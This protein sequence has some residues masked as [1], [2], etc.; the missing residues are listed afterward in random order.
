MTSSEDGSFPLWPALLLAGTFYAGMLARMVFSPLLIDMERELG[1]SHAAAGLFFLLMSAGYTVTMLG[2]GFVSRRL[3]HRGTVLLSVLWSAGASVLVGLSGSTAMLRAA[4]FLLGAGT[5]LYLPSALASIYDLAGK[6]HRGRAIGIHELGPNLGLFTAPL[7]VELLRRIMEWRHV[8]LVLGALLGLMA[9]IYA[10][11]GRGGRFPGEPPAFASI[12][13]FFQKRAFWILTFAFCAVAA[14]GIGGYAVLPTYLV[15]ERGLDRGL[16][17][18]LVGLS[19]A[20]GVILVFF[21]GWLT[22]HVSVKRLLA[23]V[24]AGVGALTILLGILHGG[25]LVACIFLQP[26]LIPAFFP[27]GFKAIADLGPRRTHN[28]AVSLVIVFVS[29]VGGGASPAVM[30][31]LGEYWSFAAGFVI[32]G[33]VLLLSAGLTAVLKLPEMDGS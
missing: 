33:G 25:W 17:N 30:G 9:G 16:V 2:S 6:R 29:L 24:S 13:V 20:S 26:L 8:F 28:V 31:L 7:I 12:L 32:L 19:R 23:A 22:D 1:L 21:A 5:G 14:T 11:F 27:A 3:T 18:L 4:A 15:T 10:L